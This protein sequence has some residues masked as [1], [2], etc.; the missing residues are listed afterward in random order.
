MS[1]LNLA[2]SNSDKCD[3]FSDIDENINLDVASKYYD[4]TDINN[5]TQSLNRNNTLSILHT[6]IQSLNCNG[7]KLEML[8]QSI[9]LKFDIVCPKLGIVKIKN[10]YLKSHKDGGL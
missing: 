2:D 10:I 7:E 1:Q 8:L 9:D 3:F 5:M 4:T 6:N